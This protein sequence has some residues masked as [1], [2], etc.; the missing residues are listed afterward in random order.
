[1]RT[2]TLSLSRPRI[3]AWK[4]LLFVDS[5]V[6]V[7]GT[8]DLGEA[9]LRPG[10][11]THFCEHQIVGFGALWAS[12]SVTSSQ[13]PTAPASHHLARAA[14]TVQLYS[15]IPKSGFYVIFTFMK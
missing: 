12:P 4:E 15:W 10:V 11:G 13:S 9:L 2:W 7:I 3:R 6:E 1:M 8:G 5:K 14:G